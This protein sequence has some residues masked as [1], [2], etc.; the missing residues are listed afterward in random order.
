MEL[1]RPNQRVQKV[2][3][4]GE[5]VD[6]LIASPCRE[7]SWVLMNND[8]NTFSAESADDIVFRSQGMDT[9]NRD[10]S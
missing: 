4:N 6:T 7:R 5:K 9:A 1:E 8:N 3:E 2:G 10:G